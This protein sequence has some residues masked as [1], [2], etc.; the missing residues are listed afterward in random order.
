MANGVDL[1]HVKC[2]LPC[3][4]SYG[5]LIERLAV[6]LRPGGMLVLVESEMQYVSAVHERPCA[7]D[8]I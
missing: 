5:A 8:G 7:S 3:L 6:I 1:I 4:A 2:L